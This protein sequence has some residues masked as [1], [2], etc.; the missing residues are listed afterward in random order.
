MLHN[1]EISSHEK[2]Y[3]PL[4]F[5]TFNLLHRNPGWQVFAKG[6]L[7]HALDRLKPLLQKLNCHQFLPLLTLLHIF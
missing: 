3:T 6:D 2:L 4:T 5:L 1:Y 7:N